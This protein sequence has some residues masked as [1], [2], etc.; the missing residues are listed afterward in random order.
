M[1]RID[2]TIKNN[3]GRGRPRVT[4]NRDV[5]RGVYIDPD[6]WDAAGD[7]P[8]SRPDIVR[9]AFRNAVSYYKTD[10]PKLEWQL[11]EKQN[12]MLKL[13]NECAVLEKRI[14]ELKEEEELFSQM[15]SIDINK[16]EDAVS[17]TLRMCRVFKRNIGHEQFTIISK[18]SGCESASIEVF[19]KD[20]KFRPTEEDVRLFFGAVLQ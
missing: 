18:L 3:R 7:L 8:I 11:E 6:L 4:S 5:M 19:I 17:E 13:E 10:L 12:Q 2:E 1:K 15:Q 14:G 16:L 9:E 20:H